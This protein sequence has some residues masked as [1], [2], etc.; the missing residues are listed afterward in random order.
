MKVGMNDAQRIAKK[1]NE[2]HRQLEDEFAALR[3]LEEQKDREYKKTRNK[4]FD[5]GE[6]FGNGTVASVKFAFGGP[7][8]TLV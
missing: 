2:K 7:G 8:I 5:V 3:N 4:V 1:Y 6:V